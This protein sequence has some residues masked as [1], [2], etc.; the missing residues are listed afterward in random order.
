MNLGTTISGVLLLVGVALFVLAE[1]GLLSVRQT[2]LQSLAASGSRSAK[3]VLEALKEKQSYIAGIQIGSTLLGFSLAI[4]VEP[5]LTALIGSFVGFL[6]KK[7]IP[8]L[9]IFVVTFPLVVVIGL[10]PKFLTNVNAEKVSL[11]LIIPLRAWVWVMRPLIWLYS[12][13]GKILFNKAMSSDP[14]ERNA[15]P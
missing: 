15:L 9:S 6:P 2:R 4:I 13:S 12:K 14:P 11:A 3:Y 5:S 8:L 1:M 10:I 7:A